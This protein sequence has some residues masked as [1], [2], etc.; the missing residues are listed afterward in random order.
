MA[1]GRSRTLVTRVEDRK[2]DGRFS[3]LGLKTRER[4]PAGIGAECSRRSEDRWRDREACIE[5]KQSREVARSVRC[6]KKKLDQNAPGCVI[7]VFSSIGVQSSFG[8]GVVEIKG[9]KQP[10][11]VLA[12]LFPLSRRAPS[13]CFFFLLLSP[14]SH[15]LGLGNCYGDLRPCATNWMGKEALSSLCPPGF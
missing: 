13:W 10:P 5:A 2:I 15:L 3:G 7:S 6:T 8:K 12:V 11:C 9:Q 4:I 1:P 14:S